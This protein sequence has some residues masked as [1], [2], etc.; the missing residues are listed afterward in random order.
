MQ[1][2]I[3]CDMGE[4]FSL[5]NPGDDEAIMPFITG[6]NIACGFHASDPNHIR[7]AVELAKS[8]GVKTGAHFSLPDQEGFGRREMK[9][10]RDELANIIICQIGALKAF[11]DIAGVPLNHLK[12][13]APSM[14]CRAGK[15]PLHTR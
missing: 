3:N 1:V 13:H 4:S 10:E 8:Y 9:I 15:K 6:T 14:E 12:P 2:E 5:Y 7:T 11:L